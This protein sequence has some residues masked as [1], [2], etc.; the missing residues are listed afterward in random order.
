[1]KMPKTSTNSAALPFRV[2]AARDAAAS[3]SEG[4]FTLRT[5]VPSIP[6]RS[7]GL[8][9]VSSSSPSGGT[10]T[11]TWRKHPLPQGWGPSGTNSA[12]IRGRVWRW[13]LWAPR[14]PRRFSPTA[15]CPEDAE[16]EAQARRHLGAW[17]AHRCP[18]RLACKRRPQGAGRPLP[19]ASPAAFLWT[20]R[21]ALGPV[22][23]RSVQY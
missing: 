11:T 6:W 15:I 21:A 12:M 3:C 2:S 4:L 13:A 23:V 20:L 9:P 8:C 1:M 14:R 5:P 18:S 7:P 10:P 22:P 19:R 17:V 16:M